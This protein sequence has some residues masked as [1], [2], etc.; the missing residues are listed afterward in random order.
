[1]HQPDLKYN[2]ARDQFELGGELFFCDMRGPK[3]RRKSDDDGFTMVKNEIYLKSYLDMLEIRPKSIFEVG[4]FEGGS[5]VFLDQLFMPDQLTCVDIRKDR[6]TSVDHYIDRRKRADN[7]RM[8]YGMDQRDIEGLGALVDK[9]HGGTLD[10]VIDD[11]SHMYELS[12]VT[13]SALF[14]RLRP[15]GL[16]ILEDYAW[17]HHPAY[18][19]QQHPWY[20]HPALTNLIFEAMLMMSSGGIVSRVDVR[21]G[22]CIIERGHHHCPCPLVIEDQMRLRGRTLTQI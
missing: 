9:H 7:F 14:P 8:I 4:F 21:P 22:L 12:R 1:M 5:S 17:A 19:S 16:Y 15:G 2:E 18:Q 3:D 20:S 11:A 6:L 13:F 10:L